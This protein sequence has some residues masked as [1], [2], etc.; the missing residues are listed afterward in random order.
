MSSGMN[1]GYR[2][3]Q[4]KG[5]YS[6]TGRKQLYFKKKNAQNVDDEINT[7]NEKCS[8]VKYG[9]YLSTISSNIS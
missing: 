3:G 7:L 9:F 8:V 5:R 2:T 4:N 6:K 1:F